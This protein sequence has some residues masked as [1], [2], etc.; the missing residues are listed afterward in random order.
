M[1]LSISKVFASVRLLVQWRIFKIALFLLVIGGVF[2]T[3]QSSLN[4]AR[5]QN[6]TDGSS[7]FDPFASA[8]SIMDI[9]LKSDEQDVPEEDY[10]DPQEEANKLKIILYWNEW[11]SNMGNQ[12]LIDG[13]CPVTSCIFTPDRSL[14]NFSHVVLFFANNETS[15]NNTLPEYRQPHQRFVFVA[16]HASIESESLIEALTNDHRIRFDY[17]NWTMTYRQDSDI[18]FR[19]SFGAIKK[20]PYLLTQRSLAEKKKKKLSTIL[21]LMKRPSARA[22]AVSRIGSKNKLVAWYPKTCETSIHREEYVRQLG[23]LVPV[24]V[25]GPC[26]NLSCNFDCFQSRYDTLRLE[27]KFYLAFEEFWCADYITAEFYNVLDYDT[28]PI[29]LGGA[30]YETLAPLNSFINA[31]DFP[32]VGALAEYLLFLDRNPEFYSRYFEWKKVYQAVLSPKSGWCDLCRMAHDFSL[33]PKIY[34]DIKLWWVDEMKCQND[35]LGIL[36][37]AK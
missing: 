28:V 8:S 37:L 11:D 13:L 7:S 36:P 31:L 2:Y 22:R 34:K 12:P 9:F 24:D 33:K 26:G 32:S 20:L 30:D 6:S 27:Y 3:T 35:S 23:Q 19:E 18:V 29:V 17:F 5:N 14:L 15:P 25:Y 1:R 4:S 21:Q 16:R 10:P